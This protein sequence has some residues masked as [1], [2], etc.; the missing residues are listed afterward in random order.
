MASRV[1][2]SLTGAA[3]ALASWLGASA[4]PQPVDGGPTYGVSGPSATGAVHIRSKSLWTYRAPRD[5]LAVTA[6][7]RTAVDKS[8]RWR[9]VV[10]AGLLVAACAAPATAPSTVPQATAVPPTPTRLA[11]SSV[12][13]TAT[14]IPS[15][16]ATAWK[17]TVDEDDTSYSS[18]VSLGE[19]FEME[20]VV[21]N[22]GTA[23][24]PGTRFQFD[25]LGDYADLKGCIPECSVTDL[26]GIYADFPGIPPGQSATY[27][28][29]FVAKGLGVADWLVCVYDEAGAGEQVWC[30]DASTA[31][32]S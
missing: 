14:P 31:I 20:V 28:F 25:G 2:R 6:H 27:R 23:V 21:R 7:A 29:G 17:L 1:V 4:G 9:W 13:I 18:E 15:P 3:T 26:F 11:T 5:E 16:S 32:T 22:E 8:V 12:A 30:G 24:N 19:I 10:L